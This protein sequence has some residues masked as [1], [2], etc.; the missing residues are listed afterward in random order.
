MRPL[1]F[2]TTLALG[3][4]TGLGTGCGGG[5]SGKHDMTSLDVHNFRQ[6]SEQILQPTCVSS[7]CHADSNYTAANKLSLCSSPQA[8]ATATPLCAATSTLAHA[9]AALV[10]APAVNKVAVAD[11]YLR[12]KPC[13][14][15]SSFLMIK[16]NL[17]EKGTSAK[18]GFGEHMPGSGNPSLSTA[19][20]SA[21]SDWIARGAYFDEPDDVSGSVCVPRSAD[22]A[23][24]APVDL[25]TGAAGD[26]A[27][28]D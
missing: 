17:P 28:V 14:P 10:D 7:T 19:E 3:I 5:T 23:A 26:L 4:S 13:D 6:I 1:L 9:Y 20:K 8:G 18:V 11:G 15:D 16:L 27:M 22:M 25:A 12:V 24:G 2:M 21:I